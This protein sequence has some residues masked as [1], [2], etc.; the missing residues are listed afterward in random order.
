MTYFRQNENINTIKRKKPKTPEHD[1]N[2]PVNGAKTAATDVINE[3]RDIYMPTNGKPSPG[4]SHISPRPS[5]A[6]KIYT[7]YRRQE[8]NGFS[9]I[10]NDFQDPTPSMP[11]PKGKMKN[12]NIIIERGNAIPVD[13]VLNS[14]KSTRIYKEQL[15]ETQTTS[16][17]IPH[18]THEEVEREKQRNEELNARL[19]G[20]VPP[21]PGPTPEELKAYK[22][23]IYQSL[24]HYNKDSNSEA[25]PGKVM[26]LR[27]PSRDMNIDIADDDAFSFQTSDEAHKQPK[28][29]HRG[30]DSSTT[31][32]RAEK[33][34]MDLNSNHS[35]YRN[36]V[37]VQR[38]ENHYVLTE[39]DERKFDVSEVLNGYKSRHV[40]KKSQAESQQLN[41]TE[42][43]RLEFEERNQRNAERE[44]ARREKLNTKLYSD[45]QIRHHYQ[46]QQHAV[47]TTQEQVTTVMHYSNSK[48]AE[49]TPEPRIG[50]SK[51]E[52]SSNDRFIEHRNR[53]AKAI[54]RDQDG[55]V[56][57]EP[58]KKVNPGPTTQARDYF[59]NQGGNNNF[60]ASSPMEIDDVDGGSG[61]G[62]RGYLFQRTNSSKSNP[63][64]TFGRKNGRDITEEYHQN[65]ETTNVNH[66]NHHIINISSNIRRSQYKNNKNNNHHIRSRT[67]E[68]YT[69]NAHVGKGDNYVMIDNTKRDGSSRDTSARSTIK[70]NSSMQSFGDY[71]GSW[72][73]WKDRVVE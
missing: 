17:R 49:K 21:P 50:P 14:Y 73:E 3:F 8:E 20:Y 43:A 44:Q 22:N 55:W 13:Q 59:N 33:I 60:R 23:H 58:P 37:S 31:T 40:Y 52:L 12:E 67:Q 11:I 46:Q 7:K 1:A 61:R 70:S 10:S 34:A 62:G 15:P 38:I 27:K 32:P 72:L 57:V 68:D 24:T 63:N 41:P 54:E 6:K 42:I 69:T 36:H 5:S 25:Q 35:P 2:K 4:T 65:F 30:I 39:P 71:V 9:F 26:Y 45:H 16:T 53:S 18:M 29:V 51:A 28:I 56:R 64:V 19:R 66:H 48:K 47:Y